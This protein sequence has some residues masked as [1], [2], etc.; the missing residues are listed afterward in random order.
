MSASHSATPYQ[1]ADNLY[2]EG[3]AAL[4]L[5][6][7]GEALWC[8]RSGL[9]LYRSAGAIP[10]WRCLSYFGLSLA[11]AEGSGTEAIRAC[12]SAL[13]KDRYDPQL[14]LNLGQVLALAGRHSKAIQT[15]ERGL[16]EEPENED[17]A[18]A[19][20]EADRR[21][22]SVLPMLSRDHPLNVFLGKRRAR[23]S[24]RVPGAASRA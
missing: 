2:R 1:M 16:R 12:E 18:A 6:R 5:K 7:P 13:R 11:L 23:R 8:F 15:Y 17:L 3:L 4:V 24:G 20:R 19:F 9:K 22:R 14:Y 21:G 10:S